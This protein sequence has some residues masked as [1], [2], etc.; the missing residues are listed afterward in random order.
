MFDI[1]KIAVIF[2]IAILFSIFTFTLTEAIHPGPEYSDFC[3]DTFKIRTQDS[4]NEIGGKWTADDLSST[5]QYNCQEIKSNENDVTLDC[6]KNFEKPSGYCEADYT[7]SQ[8]YDDADKKHS[9]FT[10]L[11]AAIFGIIG[12]VY[13]MYANPKDNIKQWIG[14]G[15]MIG[16]LINIFFGTMMYFQYTDRFVRPLIIF[17]ELVLVIFIAIKQFSKK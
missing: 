4:C 6:R 3:N 15:F 5:A 9:L 12:I 7:C 2:V 13:G 14:S 11:F 17:V 1:R 16:G 8:N 10:F